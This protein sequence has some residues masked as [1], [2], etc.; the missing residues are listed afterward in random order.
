MK[1]SQ[2]RECVSLGN[3]AADHTLIEVEKLTREEIATKLLCAHIRQRGIALDKMQ[4]KKV[5]Y[6]AL[7]CADQILEPQTDPDQ[8]FLPFTK[9]NTDT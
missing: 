5:T 9:R 1:E 8:E 2:Q 6:L 4:M 3:R 7:S